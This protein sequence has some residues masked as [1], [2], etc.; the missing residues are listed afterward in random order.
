MYIVK[1]DTLVDVTGINVTGHID[2][3]KKLMIWADDS[4]IKEYSLN[5][6]IKNPQFIHFNTGTHQASYSGEYMNC[7]FDNNRLCIFTKKIKA[8]YPTFEEWEYLNKNNINSPS[9]CNIDEKKAVSI[10][11]AFLKKNLYEY[12]VN[13]KISDFDKI[14]LIHGG[15][16]FVI[17]F[18]CSNKNYI[19]DLRDAEI[20]IVPYNGEICHFISNHIISPYDL[21]YKPKIT[22]QKA[23]EMINKHFEQLGI[24]VKYDLYITQSGR[25]KNRWAWHLYGVKENS[26]Q[27]IKDCVIIDSETGEFIMSTFG[28]INK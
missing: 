28:P 11:Y 5:Y 18:K 4:I 12:D 19:K 23:L 14:N 2:L 27:R 21:N 20:G 6:S 1:S 15:D 3:L 25:S 26:K 7:D 17:Y 22:K 9:Y 13:A 24:K 8:R 16:R 10:A